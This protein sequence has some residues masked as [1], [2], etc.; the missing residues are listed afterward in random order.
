[1]LKKNLVSLSANII[2]PNLACC[3]GFLKEERTCLSGLSTPK[4]KPD[5]LDFRRVLRD[6][7]F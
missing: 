3:W 7:E 4:A 6:G 1:M 2:S 5:A